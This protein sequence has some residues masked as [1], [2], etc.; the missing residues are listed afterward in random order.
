MASRKLSHSLCKIIRSEHGAARWDFLEVILIAMLSFSL[1][2]AVG[3]VL[4]NIR[5]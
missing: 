3:A 1:G 2:L 5:H 4:C